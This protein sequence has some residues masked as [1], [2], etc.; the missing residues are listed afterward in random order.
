MPN[1][2]RPAW[3]LLDYLL[4]SSGMVVSQDI[5][6]A[7]P[8]ARDV[9]LLNMPIFLVHKSGKLGLWLNKAMAGDYNGQLNGHDAPAPVGDCHTISIRINWPGY[10]EWSRP[11]STMEY[12]HKY[13]SMCRISLERL[14]ELVAAAVWEFTETAGQQCRDPVWQIGGRGIRTEDINLIGLIHVCEGIWNPILQLSANRVHRRTV[15]R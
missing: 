15:A 2:N 11:I 6:I 3:L 8:S 5:Y 4:Q 14:A 1:S 12:S 13:K 7:A 9:L 10:G